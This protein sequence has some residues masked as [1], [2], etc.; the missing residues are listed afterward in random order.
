MNKAA[1][2]DRDGVINRKAPEGQYLTSWEDVEFCPGASEAISLLNRAGYLV[3]IVTNQRCI[4]KG[5]MTAY[6]L[7][8]MHAR[9]RF[10]FEAAGATIDAIYYC[11][12]GN[13]A[14]CSCRKPKPGML[15]RAARTYDVDLARSRVRRS[16]WGSCSLFIR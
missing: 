5:F 14:P 15:L 10:T 1:F 6:E 8:R 3:V 9:M 7:E 4:A 13:K 11:P 2:L 12:H 16:R